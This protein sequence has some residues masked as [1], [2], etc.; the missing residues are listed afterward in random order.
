MPLIREAHKNHQ[1]IYIA[2]FSTGEAEAVS[3]T[4]DCER[5]NIPVKKLF[6]LDGVEKAKIHSTVI[7]LVDI[8]GTAPYLFRRS[9]RYSESDLEN[10]STNLKQFDLGCGHLDVPASA[11]SIFLNEIPMNN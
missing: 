5:E 11:Y 10:K 8:V 3:L 9:G 4:E 7:S 1:A 6:L 2:G